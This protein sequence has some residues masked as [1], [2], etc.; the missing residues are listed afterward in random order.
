M[1]RCSQSV[2]FD[3]MELVGLSS[4][5]FSAGHRG[6]EDAARRSAAGQAMTGP[7]PTRPAARKLMRCTA[8]TATTADV[9]VDGRHLLVK[10]KVRRMRCPVP[11][12]PPQTFREQLP[13]VLDRC[14]RRVA[15]L[16]GQFSAAARRVGGPHADPSTAALGIGVSGRPHSR[17]LRVALPTLEVPR[18]SASTTSPA[19]RPRSTRRPSTPRP[20]AASTSCRPL[21]A[22]V[23]EDWLVEHASIKVV[24]RSRYRPTARQS[25]PAARMHAGQQPKSASGRPGRGRP[26]R[27]A[28]RPA[29]WAEEPSCRKASAPGP[30]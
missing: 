30:R 26:R 3:A 8:I 2:M 25:A 11:R 13:S 19:A 22:D 6:C 24:Y 21:P 27:C 14:Q 12:S 23:T 16:T 1:C 29:C 10:V 4:S 18:S 9:P 5:V 15:R 7:C 17:H 20:A 28:A